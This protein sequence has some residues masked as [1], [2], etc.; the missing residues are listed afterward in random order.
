M[1]Q[2]FHALIQ[3]L[4]HRAA[5]GL[6]LTTWFGFAPIAVA[7][8][9]GQLTASPSFARY[10]P[11]SANCFVSVDRLDRWDTKLPQ[12]GL[13]GAVSVSGGG[14]A[15]VR[16][17][18]GAW[19][20]ALAQTIGGGSAIDLSVLATVPA[21][22]AADSCDNLAH[23]VWFFRLP[24]V[25]LLDQWIPLASRKAPGQSEHALMFRTSDGLIVALRD[26]MLLLA[27]RWVGDGLLIQSMQMMTGKELPS[28]AQSKGYGELA[29]YLPSHALGTAYFVPPDVSNPAPSTGFSR[30]EVRRMILGV[31]DAGDR[32]DVAI[33]GRLGK[34]LERAPL[35]AD[36]VAQ[37][38]R[39]PSSTLL[40]S[41]STG[42]VD[43]NQIGPSA[44]PKLSRYAKLLL[45]LRGA[46]A[47]ANKSLPV[48][49]PHMV[50]AWGQDL[51]SPSDF[52]QVTVLAECVDAAM[53][54]TETDNLLTSVLEAVRT[55]HSELPAQALTIKHETHLGVGISYVSPLPRESSDRLGVFGL[56]A[57][58]ELAWGAWGDWIAVS[59]HRAHLK[60]ILDAQ[61]GLAPT[62]GSLPGG[63][64]VLPGHRSA[65]GIVVM[66]G[67]AVSQQVST[68]LAQGSDPGPLWLDPLW[69][70]SV[71]SGD[72]GKGTTLG[73]RF[74]VPAA[75]GQLTVVSVEPGTL[76][77]GRLRPGDDIIGV[78]G[79]L[80]RLEGVE[81]D[82]R[83]QWQG[84]SREH[85]P[86]LRV[87]RDGAAMDVELPQTGV[88]AA[89]SERFDPTVA[90]QALRDAGRGVG[91]VSYVVNPSDSRDY[92]ALMSL[93]KPRRSTP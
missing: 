82:F 2:A 33:R 59:T 18:G 93:Q 61:F 62:L 60:Q 56:L 27:R 31:Y 68:W 9:S 5:C 87:R 86:V 1:S 81:R 12:L 40:A 65:S 78:N 88:T 35:R 67:H 3:T 34:K 75:P 44:N 25:G 8:T 28:L 90:L 74:R 24:D 55:L 91:F 58:V 84:R 92:A 70:G 83:R 53:M 49:G 42:A 69:W 22:V 77:E 57:D 17:Q 26:D 16:W 7:Q 39:L 36:M 14:G 41:V 38:L 47:D 72:L 85:A 52:P 46:R 48:L 23:A 4:R 11:E 50:L 15:L 51:T 76:A 37:L 30:P 19:R 43:L 63:A 21:G 32:V 80:F 13:S 20:E 73:V 29:A 45:T 89:E 64:M 71:L 66:R 79:Q 10:V 6:V 54:T